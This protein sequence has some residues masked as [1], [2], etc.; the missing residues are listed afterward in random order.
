VILD[1]KLAQ[2]ISPS[3]LPSLE[4]L[5]L[6]HESQ[7]VADFLA[8]SLNA[9]QKRRIGFQ[10]SVCEPVLINRTLWEVSGMP[11]EIISSN[12]GEFCM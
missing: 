8:G 11:H 7:Y 3:A 10:E 12:H 9:E 6:A 5:H 2:V 1:I 4:M